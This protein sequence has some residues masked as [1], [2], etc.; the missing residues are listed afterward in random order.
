MNTVAKTLLL[1]AN[2]LALVNLAQAGVGTPEDL[3]SRARR[4]L[5]QSAG[6]SKRQTI[7]KHDG[8]KEICVG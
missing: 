7:L 2:L 8:T 6:G 1:L 4:G 3:L 5:T